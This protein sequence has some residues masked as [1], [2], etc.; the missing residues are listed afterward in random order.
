MARLYS[1]GFANARISIGVS[2][3]LLRVSLRR[4]LA[5]EKEIRE[6]RFFGY[7]GQIDGAAALEEE[8][9]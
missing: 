5:S 1:V 4:S 9:L 6:R 2:S 7:V 8:V 3:C